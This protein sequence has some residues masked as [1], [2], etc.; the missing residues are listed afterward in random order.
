[1]Y[2]HAQNFVGG[3][4]IG[5]LDKPSTKEDDNL[6]YVALGGDVCCLR[7]MISSQEM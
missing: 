4:R 1:M 7:D 6:V 5:S 3:Q 2:V